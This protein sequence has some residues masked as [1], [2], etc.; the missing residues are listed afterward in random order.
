MA[1]AGVFQKNDARINRKGRPKTFDAFRELAQQVAHEVAKIT[2]NGED[3][4]LVIDGH[5]VTVAEAIIRSW[6]KSSD[7]KLQIAFVEYAFG[8][9]P[10]KDDLQVSGPNGGELPVLVITDELLERLK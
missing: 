3:A 4:E 1:K 10:N 8:K 5:A 9:V 6:S 2:E 7:P